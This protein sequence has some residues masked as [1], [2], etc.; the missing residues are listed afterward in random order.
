MLHA[1]NTH[2]LARET[3]VRYYIYVA[4]MQNARWIDRFKLFNDA[5][6]SGEMKINCRTYTKKKVCSR[7]CYSRHT[8]M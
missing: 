7:D 1:Y 5:P 2:L 3:R 6:T 4:Q 8:R